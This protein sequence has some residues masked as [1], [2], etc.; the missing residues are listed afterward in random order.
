[1]HKVTKELQEFYDS[2]AEKFSNTRQRE[3]PEFE[4]ILAEI[5]KTIARIEKDASENKSPLLQKKDKSH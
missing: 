4:H 3:R 1:M 2:Q 5:Q